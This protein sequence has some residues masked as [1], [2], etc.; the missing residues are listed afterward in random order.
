MQRVKANTYYTPKHYPNQDPEKALTHRGSALGVR[1]GYLGAGRIS[2]V[3]G[4]PFSGRPPTP[5]TL[6]VTGVWTAGRNLPC[7]TAK[8]C[9][10]REG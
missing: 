7:L 10:L 5:S 2:G 4:N 9:S 8:G 3:H 6:S 1:V